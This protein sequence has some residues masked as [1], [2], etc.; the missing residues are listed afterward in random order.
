M[1]TFTIKFKVF[2]ICL[3]LKIE[4]ILCRLYFKSKNDYNHKFVVLVFI[5]FLWNISFKF[6]VFVKLKTNVD[7]TLEITTNLSDC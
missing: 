5:Y 4:D 7:L 2:V 6:K 3:I 1:P